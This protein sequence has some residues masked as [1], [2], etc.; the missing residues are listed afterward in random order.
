MH[1]AVRGHDPVFANVAQ[2]RAAGHPA[3]AVAVAVAT[4]RT[5]LTI[6]GAEGDA[7]GVGAGVCLTEGP[8]E[9]LGAAASGVRAAV[10]WA[11]A[12]VGFGFGVGCALGDAVFC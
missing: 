10:G 6:T 2:A 4:G 5:G 9:E 3:Y 1:P 8:V 11:V 12:E 7:G